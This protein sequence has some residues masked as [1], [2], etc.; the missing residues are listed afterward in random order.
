MTRRKCRFE[1]QNATWFLAGLAADW[2]SV[3]N[4]IGLLLRIVISLFQY[5]KTFLAM[6]ATNIE[7]ETAPDHASAVLIN[8]MIHLESL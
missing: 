5:L 6:T 1:K 2:N 3:H 8:L 4:G 7:I